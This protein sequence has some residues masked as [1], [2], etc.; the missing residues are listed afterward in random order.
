MSI[1]KGWFDNHSHCSIIWR[2]HVVDC[3]DDRTLGEVFFERKDHAYMLALAL[4]MSPDCSGNVS[5]EY[6]S[7]YQKPM[8]SPKVKDTI[9]YETHTD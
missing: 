3:G 1:F 8:F 2:V 5:V 9:N 4:L 7:V 6:I